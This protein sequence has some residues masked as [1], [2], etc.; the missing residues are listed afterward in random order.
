[1]LGTQI[2]RFLR[3]SLCPD[4]GTQIVPQNK[5]LELQAP[6]FIYLLAKGQLADTQNMNSFTASLLYLIPP[7]ALKEKLWI[8]VRQ[9]T[10]GVSGVFRDWHVNRVMQ[11]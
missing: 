10:N 1:M 2:V 11:L 9:K 8:L 7:L 3:F 6:D 5:S 4:K